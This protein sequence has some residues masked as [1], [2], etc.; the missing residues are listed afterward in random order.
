MRQ[1][2]IFT[3][4][5]PSGGGKTS[6]IQALLAK[7]NDLRVGVSHT[8]R[9]ARP[10]EEDGAH[11]HFVDEA[12]YLTMRKNDE[13]AEHATVF[14]YYYGTSRK[15]LDDSISG[16]VDV[17]LDIDWQ[18]A[19][20]VKAVYPERTVGI[21]LLPPSQHTLKQRLLLRN[22]DDVTVIEKRMEKAKTEMTHYVDYDY[23]IINDNFEH[24]LVDLSSIV[25]SGRLQKPMQEETHAD[26][27]KALLG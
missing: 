16:G 25:K 4:S 8:T 5:G 23:V 13:F 10:G 7:T 15:E 11:Y 26:L 1:G 12:T 24:A 18:G 27:I 19:A 3:V 14:D 17:L 2:L 9:A 21:F 20:Q 6:L 22:Q